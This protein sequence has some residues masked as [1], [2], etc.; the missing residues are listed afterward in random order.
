[1]KKYILLALFAALAFLFAG[2]EDLLDVEETFTFTYSF[3]VDTD[4]HAFSG[5][6]L[7]NL[8]DDVDLIGEYGSKIKEVKIESVS[9]WL[10][11]FSGTDTQSIESGSLKVS[12]ADGENVQP[13][14]TLNGHYLHELLDN[15]QNLDINEAG[16]NLLNEL[17]ENPPHSFQLHADIEV[18]EGPLD[19]T[20]VFEFT[21]RMVANP[22][23]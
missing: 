23:E 4:E 20:A 6:Q 15:P 18:N 16:V 13:I 21:A 7:I 11:E 9:F 12:D 2:C 10:T 17:A 8:S 19:F 5:S 1:M 14:T 22:L 3:S